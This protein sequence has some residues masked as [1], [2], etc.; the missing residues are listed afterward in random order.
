MT[1]RQCGP[2]CLVSLLTELSPFALVI[3]DFALVLPDPCPLALAGTTGK[4]VVPGR[5]GRKAPHLVMRLPWRRA[6][7]VMCNGAGTNAVGIKIAVSGP[8]TAENNLGYC[9]GRVGRMALQ[10]VIPMVQV[11]RSP[12]GVLRRPVGGIL[13]IACPSNGRF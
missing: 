2:L 12:L 13:G 9:A 1:R 8:E 4:I 3:A 7:V 6:V 5:A 11:A 10:E